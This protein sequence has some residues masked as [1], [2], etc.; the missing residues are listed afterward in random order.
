MPDARLRPLLR[1]QAKWVA[2]RGYPLM[3]KSFLQILFLKNENLF[4]F[5]FHQTF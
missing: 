5:Y 3:A 1:G 4:V 2:L